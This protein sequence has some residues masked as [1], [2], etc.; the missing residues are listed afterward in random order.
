MRLGKNGYD[1]IT[2]IYACY[3]DAAS[4]C[5]TWQQEF[6]E[7][8]WLKADDFEDQAFISQNQLVQLNKIADIYGMPTQ[9]MEDFD[10]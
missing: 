1:W 9:T 5:S 3:T 7:S 10:A 4:L 6:L 8:F 2:G